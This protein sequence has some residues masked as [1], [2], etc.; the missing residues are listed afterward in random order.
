MLGE[1]AR[2]EPAF[3]GV[4]LLLTAVATFGFGLLASWLPARSAL[5][6]PTHEALV[7]GAT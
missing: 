5:K 3:S 1:G 2:L 4:G 6:V 7:Q